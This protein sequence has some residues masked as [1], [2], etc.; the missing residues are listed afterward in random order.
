MVNFLK[1][2]TTL[3]YFFSLVNLYKK[4]LRLLFSAHMLAFFDL[5]AKFYRR[6]FK[7]WIV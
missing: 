2:M 7:T 3:Y 6:V 4:F 5:N 1:S